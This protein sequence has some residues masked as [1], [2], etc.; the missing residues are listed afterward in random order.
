MDAA[1]VTVFFLDEHQIIKPD[2][3]GTVDYLLDYARGRGLEVERIDLRAH[4]RCGGSERYDQWVH[5]LMELDE[6]EPMHWTDEPGFQVRLAESP[7]V[8][9]AVIRERADA[10]DRARITAGI[11]WDWSDPDLVKRE[12][13]LD[14]HIGDWQ[15]P[16]NARDANQYCLFPH[17][18]D[19]TTDPRGIDQV[20]CVYTAQGLEYD[21]AGVIIGPD[22]R[23]EHGRVVTDRSGSRESSLESCSEETADRIIRNVY[24]ILLTRG[25]KGTVIH[26]CDP[27]LQHRLRELLNP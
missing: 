20:G 12:L 1:N 19:W 4:F 23:F 18:D 17:K 27:A 24:K 22:V 5:R 2:E 14:I 25:L 7:H 11:C 16:W 10:G 3:V 6:A 21:W 13:P 15:A 26:A 8:L 9:E